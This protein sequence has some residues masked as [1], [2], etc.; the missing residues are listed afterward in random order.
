MLFAKDITSDRPDE[1]A[2]QVNDINANVQ[3]QTGVAGI[4][5]CTAGCRH[6]FKKQLHDSYMQMERTA[7]SKVDWGGGGGER[8]NSLATCMGAPRGSSSM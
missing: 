5:W 8:Q 3:L 4:T 6:P 2:G 7:H 1:D